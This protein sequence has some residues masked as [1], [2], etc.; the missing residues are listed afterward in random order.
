LPAAPEV[1]LKNQ[2]LAALRRQYDDLVAARQPLRS[3]DGAAA[4]KSTDADGDLFPSFDDVPDMALQYLRLMRELKVQETLYALLV[5]Q[6]EQARIEEQKNTPV[7]SVLDWATPGETPVYPRKMLLVALAAVAAAVWVGLV[8]VAVESLRSR[9][10][11]PA[12]ARTTAAL[13]A[14]WQRAPAWL[15][16]LEHFLVR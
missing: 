8:A 11:A 13:A 4:G 2:E 7:L 16:R 14:D 15:R 9:R 1:R 3:L 12:E 6:L 5:Q 10:A